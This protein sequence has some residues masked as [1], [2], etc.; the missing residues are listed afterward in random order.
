MDD[1]KNKNNNSKIREAWTGPGN[2]DGN[3]TVF[4]PEHDG[5]HIDMKKK[6]NAEWW[7][8]D[9]RLDDGHFVVGFFRAK[10]ERTGKTGVEITIYKPDGEKIQKLYDY[11]HSDLTASNKDA[12][13]KIG[14]NYIKV[15]FSN[16]KL[17][18]YEIF[19]DEGDYGIHLKYKATVQSYMP[20]NGFTEFGNLGHFGWCIALPRAEIEGT[21]KVDGKTIPAR[22]I[23]YHD[24]NWLNFNLVRVV[25]Y[26]YWG[27]IYSDNFTLIYAYIK[28]NK[29][30]NGH[31]IKVLMF[32]KGEDIL[33][34]TGESDIIAE[35]FQFHEH[36]NNYYPKIL[37][38]DISDK[39]Y[40]TLEVQE[41]IDADNLLFE[42][43]PVLRFIVKNVLKLKPGYFRLNSKFNLDIEHDGKVYQENGN[44]LHEMVIA[45]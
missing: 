9:A 40:G 22:G 23:G 24:H 19:L 25:E 8:F 27:R 21:I 18:E 38:F 32:A 15:D 35:D 42:L 41:L 5:L 13:V 45:K 17:P 39:M 2:K 12:N 7:Y 29:K 44:T 14:N 20:G 43:S 4:K 26:W 30:M 37:K 1:V 34:S 16:N 31:G 3:I 36:V 11:S 10:H 28:C 33:L 6:G